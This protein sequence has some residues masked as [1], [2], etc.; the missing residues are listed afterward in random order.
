[1]ISYF[2]DTT[3]PISQH[4]YLITEIT[5]VSC[6]ILLSGTSGFDKQIWTSYWMPCFRENVNG[7]YYFFYWYQESLKTCEPSCDV[8]HF[9]DNITVSSPGENHGRAEVLSTIPASISSQT[10]L[11]TVRESCSPPL[12][13]P[14]SP[15]WW[16]GRDRRMLPHPP[17]PLLSRHPGPG[18]PHSLGPVSVTPAQPPLHYPGQSPPQHLHGVHLLHSDLQL[19]IHLSPGHWHLLIQPRADHD[20]QP[21]AALQQV[22]LSVGKVRWNK[23]GNPLVT[24]R[25]VF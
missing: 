23:V 11:E 17:G 14:S 7:R 18:E 1:M 9:S 8:C 12:R 19:Q 3:L 20:W 22:Q 21:H 2:N 16:R 15:A 5:V 25:S 6:I 4:S 10:C 24:N 13:S